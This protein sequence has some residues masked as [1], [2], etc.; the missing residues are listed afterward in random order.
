MRGEDKSCHSNGLF[1]VGKVFTS[2][3][4]SLAS[5]KNYLSF[6]NLI[7][8]YYWYLGKDF[9]GLICFKVRSAVCRF[10][11]LARIGIW[12]FVYLVV[13]FLF[14]TILPDNLA[15]LQLCPGCS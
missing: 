1:C 6:R 2:P 14:G 3:T 5:L 8:P 7:M 13:I 4:S 9:F 10:V 11:S 15:G 12:A